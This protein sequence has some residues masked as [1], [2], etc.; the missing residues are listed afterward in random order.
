MRRREREDWRRN[1]R[2]NV[3]GKKVWRR[4]MDGREEEEQASSAV[5]QFSSIQL[6]SY[7]VYYDTNFLP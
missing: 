3:K 4:E 7:N 1:R 5:G 6:Y 2:S